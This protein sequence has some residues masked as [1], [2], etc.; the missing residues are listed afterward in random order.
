MFFNEPH[1]MGS[2]VVETAEFRAALW[3]CRSCKRAGVKPVSY[4]QCVDD[5]V[6]CYWAWKPE[7]PVNPRD[8]P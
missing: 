5:F 6:A 1:E 3:G 8:T 7:A 4:E 2:A